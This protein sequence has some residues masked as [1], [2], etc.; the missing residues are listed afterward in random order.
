MQLGGAD[1]TPPHICIWDASTPDTAE[2]A[3]LTLHTKGVEALAWSAD[4]TQ[5][6]SG[7]VPP[8][9]RASATPVRASAIPC[10]GQCHLLSGPVPPPC[11]GQCQGVEALVWSADGTQVGLGFRRKDH[12]KAIVSNCKQL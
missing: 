4:G 10:P 1:G 12:R 7:P 2:L 11:P 8:P 5:V 3:R 9:V 6:V